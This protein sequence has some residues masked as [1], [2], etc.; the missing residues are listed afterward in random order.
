MAI[1]I[2]DNGVLFSR[3]KKVGKKESERGKKKMEKMRLF[4]KNSKDRIKDKEN[5]GKDQKENK[6]KLEIKIRDK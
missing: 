3:Q 5:E 4:D 6:Y 1:L 2:S